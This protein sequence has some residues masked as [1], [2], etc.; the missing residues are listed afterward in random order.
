MMH[1][2]RCCKDK[3]EIKKKSGNMLEANFDVEMKI[4]HP[5]RAVF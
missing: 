2:Y 5:E 4:N 3:L 1:E